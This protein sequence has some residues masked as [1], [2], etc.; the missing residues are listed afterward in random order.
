MSDPLILEFVSEFLRRKGVRCQA[1]HKEEDYLGGGTWKFPRQKWKV[2]SSLKREEI[3]QLINQELRGSQI[4]ADIEKARQEV[5]GAS[6]S[7][8]D[9]EVFVTESGFVYSQGEVHIREADANGI[10]PGTQ[11]T[12]IL[13][14]QGF[15]AA[16]P[17][18]VTI[19][20]KQGSD[21]PVLSAPARIECD[22]DINQR[23]HVPVTLPKAGTWT[24]DG[25]NDDDA[26]FGKDKGTITI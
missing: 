14:G 16:D 8:P 23:A 18:K 12:V 11:G 9:L 4:W 7:A 13:R 22:V 10:T 19:R 26:D 21:A 2:L 20:F 17:S 3:L 5:H 25:K 6:P 1:M 15:H 24:I